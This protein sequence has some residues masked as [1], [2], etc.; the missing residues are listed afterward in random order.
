L[1]YFYLHK[2][3]TRA[4][5]QFIRMCELT[6]MQGHRIRVVMVYTVGIAIAL[7]G[8]RLAPSGN[9]PVLAASV[10]VTGFFI[11]GPQML[12]GLIGAHPPLQS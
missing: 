8:L 11:Y 10:A 6:R 5:K 9:L 7:L 2:F 4:F 12:I 3:T 1:V